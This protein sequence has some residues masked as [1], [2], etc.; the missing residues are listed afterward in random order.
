MVILYK[1]QNLLILH[2][3]SFIHDIN[4]GEY[5][6]RLGRVTDALKNYKDALEYY[7]MAIVKGDPDKYYGCSA[8]FTQVLSMKSKRN[9]RK[10]VSI[11]TNA[12]SLYPEG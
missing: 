12:F 2:S 6:Y 5:Y 9:S 7:E 1:A 11:L 3:K 10:H 8:C 4:D